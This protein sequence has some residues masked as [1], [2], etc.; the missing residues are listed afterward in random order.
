L[1]LVASPKQRLS[2]LLDRGP[3]NGTDMS[4]DTIRA[5]GLGLAAVAD[6]LLAT[7]FTIV[8]AR[9]LGPDEYG[10]LAALISA[11]LILAVGGTGLQ[12]TVVREIG[13]LSAA[14][15]PPT[16]SSV[17]RWSGAL[18]LALVGLLV[19]SAASRDL[20]ATIIGVDQEWAAC[21]TVSMAGFW[22]LISFQRGVLLGARRY[23]TV[24][25]SMIGEPAGWLLFGSAAAF[26]G[27]GVTGV[28][29]G[30]A[31][32]EIMVAVLLQARLG[33]H[34]D[35]DLG[36]GA[37]DLDFLHV[38]R[39]AAIPMTALVLFAFLQNVD[40]IA[41]KHLASR[42][43]AASSYAA[44]SMAAKVII[45]L[46]IGVGLY[47]LPE[48][49]RRAA[50]GLDGRP[51]LERG[52]GVLLTAAAPMILLYAV[53]GRFLLET[54]FG[55]GLASAAD[56]LSLLGVAMTLLA[57]TYL[58]VQYEL[59]LRRKTFLFLLAPAALIEP[60]LLWL[61][62]GQFIQIALALVG[63][64]LILGSSL[65]ALSLRSPGSSRLIGRG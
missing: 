11:F 49:A 59:A 61:V 41:V 2:A 35:I 30:I 44:A 45:W 18:A 51:V 27:L 55:S 43:A 62:G 36:P 64:Q 48:A 65:L 20:L 10:S 31:V 54:V 14:G 24:G 8:L 26:A 13:W 15:T 56:A 57:V 4:E 37:R 47:V 6:A 34:T 17:R 7:I 63:L 58:T 53:A 50:K 32:A 38:L 40:V 12:T 33:R 52:L 46:A 5:A 16:R 29:L 3:S 19:L 42:E 23:R 9:V 25:L 22:V 1:T 60:V 21:V 28:I 39:G